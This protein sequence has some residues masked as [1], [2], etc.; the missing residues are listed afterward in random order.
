MLNLWCRRN[1]RFW[2]PIRL[3]FY[4]RLAFTHGFACVHPI[5]PPQGVFIIQLHKERIGN[6]LNRFRVLSHETKLVQEHFLYA[7]AIYM[8]HFIKISHVTNK[9]GL[10]RHVWIL[11]EE[12]YICL[13]K[14]IWFLKREKKKFGTRPDNALLVVTCDR[15][16]GSLR[17]WHRGAQLGSSK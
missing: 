15:S 5:S 6:N 16:P 4:Y 3:H 17:E 10:P 14:R 2:D 12:K 13:D 1:I 11:E 8:Q 7:L 9:R